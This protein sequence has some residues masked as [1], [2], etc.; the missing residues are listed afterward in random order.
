MLIIEEATLRDAV[1]ERE[2]LMA[3][4]RAFRALAEGAVTQPAPMGLDVPAVRGEV[5][6]KGAHLV[7]APVFAIKVASGFYLNAEKGL[8]TGSGLVLLFDAETG[9]PLAILL[10]NGYL[11]EMRTGAAGALAARLLT[12]EDLDT[13]AVIGSGAQARY[14]LRAL[15]GVRTW[16]HTRVWSPTPAHAAACAREMS[17]AL[18]VPVEAAESARQAVAGADLVIT[19]TPSREPILEADWVEAHATVVAVGSDGPEKQELSAGLMG[20]ADKIVVDSLSQCVRLGELH[21]AVEEGAVA[22]EGVHGELGEVLTGA[23]CG[24][25]GDELIVCDLTGL[26]AQDA[27][28][29]EEAWRVVRPH[30]NAAS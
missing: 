25:E 13:V 2:A 7:G 18:A 10:D 5:H 9:R 3:V 21:H 8:P 22:A 20:R 11:T 27:A 26:G 17:A 19:V 28:I 30:Q 1:S 23:K 29:A 24:R 16:R 4:E 6:V 15:A 12:P 14:Q